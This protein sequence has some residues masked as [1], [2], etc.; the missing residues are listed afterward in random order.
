MIMDLQ[1]MFRVIENENERAGEKDR[2]AVLCHP[3]DLRE[4]EEVARELL[5]V[6]DCRIYLSRCS[7]NWLSESEAEEL[8]TALSEMSLVA[9]LVSRRFLAE[10]GVVR[11]YLIPGLTAKTRTMPVQ[12]EPGLEEMFDAVIGPLQMI[13]RTKS[14][15]KIQLQ[16]FVGQCVD[17]HLRIGMSDEMKNITQG[18]FRARGFV[19]Y[20]KKD[21]VCLKQLLRALR[22][23]PG[24]QDVSLWYDNALHPGENF[25]S[26]IREKLS[27]KPTRNLSRLH[28]DQ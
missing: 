19:S 4:A 23:I 17:V 1:E 13:N 15:Y 16:A 28:L 2:V 25:N 26:Q 8:K 22:G 12:I 24:L 14:D 7:E 9:Y 18:L 20:R 21:L 27:K 3:A 6:Y 5:S 10:G 11:Q